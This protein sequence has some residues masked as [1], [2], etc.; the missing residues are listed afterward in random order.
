MGPFKH[1]LT[2]AVAAAFLLGCAS[3][4][5]A[6]D[7]AAPVI[8][9]LATYK[10]RLMLPPGAVFEATLEDVSRAGAPSE[11]IG[12]TRIESPKA[13]PFPFQI[14]YDPAKV[15]AGHRYVVRATI[16]VDGTLR[17]TTDAAYP[18]LG[19]DGKKHVELLL[20]GDG[21]SYRPI[22]SL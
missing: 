13:P 16:S 18:V 15:L 12:R 14:G 6:A 21:G 19:A 8:T 1:L 11:V 4:P 9:G 5:P 2:S 7:P 3:A 22:P 17:F 20:K 10:A